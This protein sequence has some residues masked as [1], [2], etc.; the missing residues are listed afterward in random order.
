MNIVESTY[1][2]LRENDAN[3]IIHMLR[4]SSMLRMLRIHNSIT[5]HPSF[6]SVFPALMLNTTLEELD[7][8]SCCIDNK[9]LASLFVALHNNVTLQEL[10]L[11]NNCITNCAKLMI[12]FFKHNRT[13]KVLDLTNNFFSECFIGN[14]TVF[15]MRQRSL[16]CFR[17]DNVISTY[18]RERP[19]EVINYREQWI[20]PQYFHIDDGKL[21]QQHRLNYLDYEHVSLDG[22]NH[23]QFHN[24]ITWLD[25]LNATS[26]TTF[27]ED[28]TG[29][30]DL[31]L[32]K[33]DMGGVFTTENMPN[34][35]KLKRLTILKC[36][37]VELKINE[38]NEL[39][40][41]HDNNNNNNNNNK[42]TKL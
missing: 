9:V 33:V 27:G 14:M 36:G 38:L 2:G 11:K 29:T 10:D 20:Q 4:R 30:V 1:H 26:T 23:A 18:C 35:K 37:V 6:V 24:C 25:Y 15:F 39:K 21:L 31:T 40:L 7:L 5:K 32:H 41:D 16:R 17:F 22:L 8:S 42:R 34:L 12:D 3:E 28:A 13:L 19:Y